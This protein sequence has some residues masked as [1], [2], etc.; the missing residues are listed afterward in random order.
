MVAVHW[1][2]RNNHAWYKTFETEELAMLFINNVGLV[3]HPDIT[4][5]VVKR[6]TGADIFLKG[7]EL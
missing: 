7:T 5:V 3:S 6:D 4:T 1:K 2:F